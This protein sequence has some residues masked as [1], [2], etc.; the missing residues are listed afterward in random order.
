MEKVLSNFHYM[1]NATEYRRISLLDR[2]VV[3]LKS[4]IVN[5]AVRLLKWAR[6]TL[7]STVQLRGYKL[8]YDRFNMNYYNSTT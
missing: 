5:N 4:V 6:Q 8:V 3:E 1:P 2:N 7:Y